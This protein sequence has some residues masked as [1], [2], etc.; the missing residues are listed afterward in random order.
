MAILPTYPC[1]QLAPLSPTDRQHSVS[2]RKV[3]FSFRKISQF[4]SNS[5]D[6]FSKELRHSILDNSIFH[7]CLQNKYEVCSVNVFGKT[8]TDYQSS[9]SIISVLWNVI[10]VPF[11][12]IKK[13][14]SFRKKLLPPFSTLRPYQATRLNDVPEVS[15]WSI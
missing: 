13:V 9:S 2:I 3:P 11:I 7:S 4:R 10:L 14:P 5:Y 1:S 12:L 6:T 8:T 15:D